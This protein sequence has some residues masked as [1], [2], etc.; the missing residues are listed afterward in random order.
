M[1]LSK[2]GSFKFSPPENPYDNRALE[3]GII[4]PRLSPEGMDAYFGNLLG[5]TTN[6]SSNAPPSKASQANLNIKRAES[7]AD[8]N[9]AA[10]PY[11]DYDKWNSEAVIP[12]K[13]GSSEEES[14]FASNQP[15]VYRP[16]RDEV[17]HSPQPARRVKANIKQQLHEKSISLKSGEILAPSPVPRTAVSPAWVDPVRRQAPSRPETL[18][19][20]PFPEDSYSPLERLPSKPLHKRPGGVTSPVEELKGV[21]VGQKV[22][23]SINMKQGKHKAKLGEVP[24]IPQR[25][26]HG[27]TDLRKPPLGEDNSSR[28]ETSYDM[29]REPLDSPPPLPKIQYVHVDPRK[30]YS[31][32]GE[33]VDNYQHY[34]LPMTALSEGG[35]KTPPGG[36]IKTWDYSSDSSKGTYLSD[37]D[38]STLS[39]DTDCLKPPRGQLGQESRQNRRKGGGAGK[40]PPLPVRK[41]PPLPTRKEE[42]MAKTL[43]SRNT[44]RLAGNHFEQRSQQQ[45]K[46]QKGP[47]QVNKDRSHRPKS[48]MVVRN[49]QAAGEA[50]SAGGKP[51][52]PVSDWQFVQKQKL[53]LYGGSLPRP[54]ERESRLDNMYDKSEEDVSYF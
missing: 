54:T 9:S 40:P 41:A 15:K 37:S 10:L 53:P 17:K 22:N 13:N 14:S 35:N 3:G 18:A 21:P 50:S 44:E 7:A 38:D 24:A 48:E 36:G 1:N 49:R 2:K 5:A 26:M 28:S 29:D 32:G 8:N 6:G 16:S 51:E 52:R 25:K 46:G 20:P 43:Q 33:V 11:R 4:P 23:N 45:V 31:G 42:K 30:A 39:S 34:L 12:T 19:I 47:K 27:Q